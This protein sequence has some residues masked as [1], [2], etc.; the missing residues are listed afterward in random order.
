M[1]QNVNWFEYID[2]Y[3]ERTAPGLFAEP[4]NLIS[5]AAFFVAFLVSY[6]KAKHSALDPNLDRHLGRLNFIVLCIAIGSSAFHSFANQLSMLA[7][8]IPIGIFIFYYLV[9]F[10]S[11]VARLSTIHIIIFFS[12]FLALSVFLTMALDPILLNGSQSYISTWFAVFITAVWLHGAKQLKAQRIQWTALG[13]LT[14]SIFFRM[15]DHS[16]C[17]DWEY[18]THFLW[19]ILNAFVLWH[20]MQTLRYVKAAR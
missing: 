11:S 10:L 15:I 8:V 3:C 19:H 17:D 7:D 1:E 14:M 6:K 13:L 2:Y 20:T 4:L 16:V 5:N 9:V 12:I 18:G